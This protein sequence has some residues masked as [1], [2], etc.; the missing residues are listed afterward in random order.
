MVGK[1]REEMTLQRASVTISDSGTRTKTWSDVE[2]IMCRFK[3]LRFDKVIEAAK[4][5]GSQPAEVKTWY[6]EDLAG[7]DNITQQY[8]LKRTKGNIDYIYE[9]LGVQPV[10]EG[11]CLT[12]MFQT[13][14]ITLVD[15][16]HVAVGTGGVFDTTFDNTFS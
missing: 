12:Y 10:E 16:E 14:Y 2:V 5:W 3:S 1:L 11:E 8:R 9:I 13:L 4:L 7:S 6:R 15:N